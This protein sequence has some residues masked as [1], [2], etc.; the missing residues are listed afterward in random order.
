MLLIP[1]LN[2]NTQTMITLNPH[3]YQYGSTS[4]VVDAELARQRL[5]A[6]N[7]HTGPRVGDFVHFPNEGLPRR[8]THDWNDGS[9]QTTIEGSYDS[10]FFIYRSGH[11]D[12]SGSLDSPI[13]LDH[14]HDTGKKL[15][16][17]VWVFSRNLS[18]PHRGVSVTLPFR[19]YEYWPIKIICPNCQHN[20]CEAIRFCDSC[21]MRVCQGCFDEHVFDGPCHVSNKPPRTAVP[22]I[23]SAH[24]SRC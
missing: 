20:D 1:E 18:G 8:F 4:P 19:L 11:C 22:T 23:S 21:N 16:G 5:N 10:S 24:N 3:F 17:R 13:W 2:I 15:L 9:M 12:F 6:L 14:C 7:R